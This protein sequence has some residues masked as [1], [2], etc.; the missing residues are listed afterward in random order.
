MIKDRLTQVLEYKGIPKESFYE[1]IGQKSANF[2]GANRKKAL[3]SDVIEN[4]L[5]EIPDLNLVWF[6][7]GKGS[8]FLDIQ[9][10]NTLEN[11]EETPVQRIG[12]IAKME[13]IPITTLEN[14]IGM[15]KG[16]LSRSIRVGSDIGVRWISALSE[17]YPKYDMHWLITGHG[18]M[19]LRRAESKPQ[20][21]DEVQKRL[22]ELLSQKDKEINELK[23]EFESCNPRKLV[24]A[25]PRQKLTKK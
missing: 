24:A 17:I 15:S 6:L 19:I 23:K 13:G 11:S 22:L 21:F 2:R 4:I 7:T 18:T 8:M 25:D 3:N 16:A 5:T 12:R 10:M 9:E 1:K 14:R 20:N